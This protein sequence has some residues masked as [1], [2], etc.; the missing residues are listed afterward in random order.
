[1]AVAKLDPKKFGLALGVLHGACLLVWAWVA[2]ATGFWTDAIAIMGK[3]SLYY[4]A[5]PLGGI[6]GLI[7][8]LVCGFV[9]G[10][11]FAWLYNKLK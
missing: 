3:I 11:I 2:A 1:M 4:A 5:T 8:G 10:Y 6:I 9:G 7:W